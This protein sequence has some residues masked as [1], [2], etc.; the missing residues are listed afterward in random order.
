MA[1]VSSPK[2]VKRNCIF[3]DNDLLILQDDG[4]I[5]LCDSRRTPRE[6]SELPLEGNKGFSPEQFHVVALMMATAYS[7]PCTICWIE[8]VDSHTRRFVVKSTLGGPDPLNLY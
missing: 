5:R 3:M 6:L 7:A 8:L 2:F 1:E 4:S